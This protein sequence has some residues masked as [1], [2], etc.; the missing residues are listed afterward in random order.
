MNMVDLKKLQREV[1]QNKINKN[2]NVTDIAMEFCLLYEEVSEA[3]RAWRKKLPDLGEEIAD[4]VIYLLGLSAILGINLE[5]EVLK[6]IK[7][8]EKR[9]YQKVKGALK[10]EKDA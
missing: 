5:E 4:V 6:K 8:N 2:F 7:K 1:Y 3:Y 9:Q 10:R